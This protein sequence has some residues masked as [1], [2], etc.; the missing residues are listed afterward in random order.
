[1]LGKPERG[2]TYILQRMR[3]GLLV[4][5]STQFRIPPGSSVHILMP[6]AATSWTRDSV[7][8]A[9]C[10]EAPRRPPTD[11]I[12]RIQDYFLD[13]DSRS[14]DSL[15]NRSRMTRR[16]E[17][18]VTVYYVYV[19]YEGGIHLQPFDLSHWKCKNCPYLAVDMAFS[20]KSIRSIH[21][22]K[23]CLVL[24]RNRHQIDTK[25]GPHLAHRWSVSSRL[26]PS[27]R[28]SR[29]C[30]APSAGDGRILG[31]PVRE[32]RV[33]PWRQSGRPWA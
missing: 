14:L 17:I 12:C 9:C 28:Q 15:S 23:L 16:S 30:E 3:R 11:D 24:S 1:L 25:Q 29:T 13:L 18:K 10:R 32:G 27:R 2:R 5:T 26:F 4:R 20:R 8:K 22:S 6:K 31:Y 19:G 33:A 7:N 21:S